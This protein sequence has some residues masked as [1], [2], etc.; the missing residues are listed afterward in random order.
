MRDMFVM[1][2]HGTRASK[3]SVAVGAKLEGLSDQ[4]MEGCQVELFGLQT[5]WF[6]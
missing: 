4:T 1:G 5:N 6:K 3:S 2:T